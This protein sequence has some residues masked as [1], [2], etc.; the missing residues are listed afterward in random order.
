[1]IGGMLSNRFHLVLWHITTDRL[2]LFA[3][4]Q[5]VVGPV[6]SLPHDAEFAGL[7][8]VNVGDLFEKFRRCSGIHVCIVYSC[9][10]TRNQK[11][12]LFAIPPKFVGHPRLFMGYL[13]AC[14]SDA[15]RYY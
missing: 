5:V 14:A 6:W 2:P 10:Y 7:H 3:A 9:V 12:H 15:G 13:W 1:M 4:L 8:P 11:T